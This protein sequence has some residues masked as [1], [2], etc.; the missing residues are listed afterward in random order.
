MPIWKIY[1]LFF[2]DFSIT[3]LQYCLS[4]KHQ[5]LTLSI[6]DCATLSS[7]TRL[8]HH[9]S[10]LSPQLAFHSHANETSCSF[11]FHEAIRMVSKLCDIILYYIISSTSATTQPNP[12]HKQIVTN[13]NPFTDKQWL[14]STSFSRLFYFRRRKALGTRF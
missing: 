12:K 1:F 7:T 9:A 6:P 8:R 14:T 11:V 10:D 4:A 13:C 2:A 3:C 5:T